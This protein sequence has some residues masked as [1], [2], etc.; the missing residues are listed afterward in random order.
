VIAT[1]I[2]ALG[3][4]GRLVRNGV[5][6]FLLAFW[7]LTFLWPYRIGAVVS[8]GLAL[9]YVAVQV[10]GS[11]PCPTCGVAVFRAPWSDRAVRCP[12]CGDE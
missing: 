3:P 6:V 10:L 9:G 7:L 5:A 12:S 11:R 4:T 8:A 1:G 2:L